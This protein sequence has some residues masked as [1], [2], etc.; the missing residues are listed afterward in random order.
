MKPLVLWARWHD[1]KLRLHG[2]T[3]AE[4]WGELDYW[5]EERL[6]PFRFDLKESKL[7]AEDQVLHLDDAGVEV[8]ES[9]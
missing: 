1:A 6:V 5:K 3:P 4:V 7:S 8:K 9:Q 2:R